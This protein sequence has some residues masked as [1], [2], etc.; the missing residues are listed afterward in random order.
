M[1]LPLSGGKISILKS[2]FLE[3]FMWSDT[4]IVGIYKNNTSVHREEE[5]S[6]KT[7]N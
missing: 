3:L 5:R 1:L 4:F 6:C 7:M 2:V